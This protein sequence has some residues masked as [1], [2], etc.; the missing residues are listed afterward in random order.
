MVGPGIEPIGAWTCASLV[1]C[2]TTEQS[3]PIS[4]PSRLIYQIPSLLQGLCPQNN[5]I[6][7][8]L[9][10]PFL[11]DKLYKSVL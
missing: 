7:I 1:R 4:S 6:K 11:N 8:R 9:T 5:L 3:R 2:S 10:N